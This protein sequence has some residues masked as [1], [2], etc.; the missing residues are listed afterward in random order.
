MRNLLDTYNMGL[1]Y[2]K[3]A[4]CFLLDILVFVGCKMD[5]ESNSDTCHFLGHSL[6]SSHSKKKKLAWLL[7]LNV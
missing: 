1:W 7:P 3:G 4:S 5:R 2:A 6:F